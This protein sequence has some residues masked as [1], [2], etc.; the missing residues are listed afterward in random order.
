M[1][2]VE[3]VIEP[4]RITDDSGGR[5]GVETCDGKHS[6]LAVPISTIIIVLQGD[7]VP[8]RRLLCHHFS[9]AH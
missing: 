5:P 1:A 9:F 8:G 7:Q 6:H 2:Q 4:D 3:P